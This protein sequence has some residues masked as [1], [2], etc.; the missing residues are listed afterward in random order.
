MDERRRAFDVLEEEAATMRVRLEA[1]THMEEEF[2]GTL[3]KKI[4]NLR[5]RFHLCVTVLD[6][7]YR[8][9]EFLL[10]L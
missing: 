5:H 10:L 2:E 8:R 6:C 1:G 7:N 9:S 3:K 4:Q